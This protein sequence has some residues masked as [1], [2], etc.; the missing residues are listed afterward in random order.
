MAYIQESNVGNT[1]FERL[2]GH[3]PQILE[4]WTQLETELFQS[5]AFTPVLREQV[6]RTLAFR[7]GCKY[8]MAKGRPD[9]QFDD[10]RTAVAVQLAAEIAEH[11]AVKPEV[12][13]RAKHTFTDKELSELCAFICFITAEQKFGA[14]MNLE[15]VC[16]I[17]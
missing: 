17:F 5:D 4:K 11:G 12:M 10:E 9:E 13:E 15:A 2:L 8:C 6:R 14:A 7:N 1:P 16:S 3:H